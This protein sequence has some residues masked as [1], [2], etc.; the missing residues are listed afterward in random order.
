MK[1]KPE[2]KSSFGRTTAML[3]GTLA[4]SSVGGILAIGVLYY[5]QQP[6]SAEPTIPPGVA[7][8]SWFDN[9]AGGQHLLQI[10]E[11]SAPPVGVRVTGIVASDTNCDPDALGLSHCHNRIELGNGRRIEVTNTHIMTRHPC[12]SPGQRLSITRLNAKWVIA[13]EG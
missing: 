5:G 4:L 2:A 11:G 10:R 9:G 12:L 3:L 13:S 6:A 1:T 8:T 7:L